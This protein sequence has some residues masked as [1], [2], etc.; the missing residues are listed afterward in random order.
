MIRSSVV[1]V[2]RQNKSNKIKA[3]KVRNSNGVEKTMTT[4]LLKSGIM[5]GEKYRLELAK[6]FKFMS[7]EHTEIEKRAT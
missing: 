7:L 5:R 4:D 2:I 1:E 3:Y 6:R